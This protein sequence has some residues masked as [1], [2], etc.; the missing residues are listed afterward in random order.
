LHVSIN[1]IAGSINNL[2]SKLRVSSKVFDIMHYDSKEFICIG[3]L[4][5]K[6][7]EFICMQWSYKTLFRKVGALF[8]NNSSD[9]HE[10]FK[11]LTPILFLKLE[12]NYYRANYKK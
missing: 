1:R 9:S 10:K 5:E 7:I 12:P 11:Y 3:T 8:M 6:T 2:W 4:E